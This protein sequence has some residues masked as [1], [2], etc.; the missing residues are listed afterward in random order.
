M[1]A[2]QILDLLEGSLKIKDLVEIPY[3]DFEVD[4]SSLDIRSR[5]QLKKAG[6]SHA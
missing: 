2:K 6:D 4:S 1:K 5:L 3:N